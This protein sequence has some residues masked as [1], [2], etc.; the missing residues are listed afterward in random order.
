M[1]IIAQPNVL[2]EGLKDGQSRA[3]TIVKLTKTRASSSRKFKDLNTFGD[4]WTFNPETKVRNSWDIIV[5][6]ALC[7][8]AF[9][10]PFQVC[11]DVSLTEF[12]DAFDFVIDLTYGIDMLISANTAFYGKDGTI[13]RSRKQIFQ[14][15]LKSWFLI[16]F[17]STF[18]LHHVIDLVGVNRLGKLVKLPKLLRVLRLL[19]LLKL[20]RVARIK[21]MLNKIEVLYGVHAGVARLFKLSFSIVLVTHILGCVWYLIPTFDGQPGTWSWITRHDLLEGTTK[22]K[23][24][25]AVYWT[26]TTLTTVGF[27]DVTGYTETEKAYSIVVMAIGVTWYAFI[28]SSMSTIM[29]GFDTYNA[30][31]RNKITKLNC[32]MRDAKL[33]TELRRKLRG[34]LEQASVDKANVYEAEKVLRDLPAILRT[35]VLMHLNKSLIQQF[36]FLNG[37]SKQFTVRIV[38]SLRPLFVNPGG[39]IIRE[40]SHAEEMYFLTSGTAESAKDGEPIETLEAPCYI[41]QVGCLLTNIYH[42][43]VVANDFCELYSIIKR[44]LRDIMAEYPVFAAEL[45]AQALAVIETEKA[46]KAEMTLISPVKELDDEVSKRIEALE[47]RMNHHL[48]KIE[49]LVLEKLKT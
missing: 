38:T 33:P 16:D 28:V 34:H 12:W 10:A 35:D 1:G 27:G 5:M 39:F 18:P 25:T 11:F 24:V 19:R 47:D 46:E 6:L 43:S 45:R 4:N 9:M 44:E 30:T 21:A 42:V 29:G 26:F 41:G 3:S 22:D 23:Y 2:T 37:K 8:T 31:M 48:D 14:K 20:L 32:F 36:S 40:G 17:V 15:Y 7:Y 13:V 49:K